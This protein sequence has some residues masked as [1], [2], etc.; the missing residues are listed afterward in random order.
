MGGV[1]PIDKD[2]TFQPMEFAQAAKWVEDFLSAHRIDPYT[3]EEIAEIM[4]PAQRAR[5][6][7]PP[8]EREG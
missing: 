8:P 2:G 3:P 4:A 5:V 1:M 7:A 6:E